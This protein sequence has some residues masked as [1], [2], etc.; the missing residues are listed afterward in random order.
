VGQ[1]FRVCRPGADV[2]RPAQ[3]HKRPG[4]RADWHLCADSAGK[5]QEAE[6]LLHRYLLRSP[7]SAKANNLLGIVHLRQGHFEQAEDALQKAIA[8]APALLE[9]RLNLGDAY[10]AEGKLGSAM[11]AYQGAAEIAPHDARANLAL[12]K[13]YLGKEEF[14]KSIEAAGNIPPQKRTAEL[15]PTLA[16]NY[17]GL[18]QQEKAD[19]EIQAMLQVAQKQPDLVPELAEFFL[20]HRDFQSSSNCLRSRNPSSRPRTVFLWISLARKLV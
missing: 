5:L 19:V 1:D 12:A 2:F 16:A 10:L 20:A 9:S 15:L 13:L 11:S 4:Q 14:A 7:H 18:R 6:Q 17:L 8:A 3:N